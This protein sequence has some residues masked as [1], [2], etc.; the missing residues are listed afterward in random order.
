METTQLSCIEYIQILGPILI[1]LLGVGIAL[2]TSIVTQ[3]NKKNDD[4]RSEINK[5]L[6]EFYAPFEQL[7]GKSNRLYNLFFETKD[8]NFRTLT[9]I[10]KGEVFSDN[11]KQLLEDI[12]NIDKQLEKM[13]IEKSGLIDKPDLR[14]LLVKAATHFHIISAAYD[15]KINGES[16]RFLEY[17]FPRELDEKISTEISFLKAKLEELNK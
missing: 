4:E 13:I 5:K 11:D 10:L 14:D 8:K 17:V 12:I 6:Y 3:R 9:A 1:G 2:Y 7:R 16:D 15:G